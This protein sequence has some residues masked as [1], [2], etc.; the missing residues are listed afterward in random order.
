MKRNTWLGIGLRVIGALVVG[1][2]VGSL[3]GSAPGGASW[4]GTRPAEA[5]PPARAGQAAANC[6]PTG[7]A[8]GLSIGVGHAQAA[9]GATL[10]GLEIPA[11]RILPDRYRWGRMQRRATLPIDYR[12]LDALVREHQEAGFTT[13]LLTLMPNA[14]WAAR[15]P[16]RNLAPQPRYWDQYESWVGGVVERY[17]GDGVRDMPGLRHGV[18]CFEV[19]V[20]LSAFEP[21]PIDVYLEVLERAYRTIHAAFS[22]AVV[23]HA[24]FLPTGAFDDDPSTEDYPTLQPKIRDP[25]HGFDDMRAVL[26]R[27]DLFDAVNLHSLSDPLEIERAVRWLRWEMEGRGYEKDILITNTAPTPFMTGGDGTTCTGDPA[28]MGVIARPA[29]EEDRCRLVAYFDRLLARDEGAIRWMWAFHAEDVVKKIVIA[30]EA[31]VGLIN[32]A[33]AEDLYVLKTP[34]MRVDAGAS[35]WGGM[36]SW[37]VDPFTGARRLEEI[38]P[39]FYALRQLSR[40]LRGY[41]RIERVTTADPSVRLYEVETPVR[42]FRIAWLEPER[43]IL[44][45]DEES[46][47]TLDLETE[48]ARLLVEAVIRRVGVEEPDRAVLEPESEI[49]EPAVG[50][51]P[52]E[53]RGSDEAERHRFEIDLTRTPIY[54]FEAG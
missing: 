39:A 15:D 4:S 51:T 8:R 37:D 29:S 44:P 24:A 30:A 19:G 33:F 36:T 27:P 35:A 21:E 13:L 50:A 32:T 22:D 43:L 12:D 52:D 40:H 41:E 31:G 25:H 53:E 42:T 18:R 45:G 9:M 28:D 47:T 34:A 17:D 48:S 2:G 46:V 10:A 6:D 23:L 5:R 11:V 1:S 16:V 54:I 26:D 3:I 7:E 20:E 14:D 38:R 49:E